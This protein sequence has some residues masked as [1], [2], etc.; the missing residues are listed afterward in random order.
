MSHQTSGANVYMTHTQLLI[1]RYLDIS[2][3]NDRYGH[4]YKHP[5][6]QLQLLSL[7]LLHLNHLDISGTNLAGPRMI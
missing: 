6:D 3:S 4:G 1:I 2:T 7:G 5:E